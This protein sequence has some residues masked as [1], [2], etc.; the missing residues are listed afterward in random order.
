MSRLSRALFALL[1]ATATFAAGYAVGYKVGSPG[2]R[3]SPMDT[4]VLD[5]T[6]IEASI[7]YSRPYV[8]G[9]RIFGELLPWGRRWRTG[10]NEATTLVTPTGLRLGG[11]EI[12]PGEYSLY[13]VPEPDSWTLIVNRQTG[14]WGT[15]YDQSL[16]LGR[17]T[18]QA[19]TTEDPVEQMTL[20]SEEHEGG[21][22]FLIEWERSRARIPLRPL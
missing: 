22:D 12:P 8:R 4:A 19:E 9:R 20:R 7:T 21:I 11:L 15:E 18:M 17:V 10:A 13:S 1:I 5:H 14:Q 2:Y 3:L 16:D 6:S